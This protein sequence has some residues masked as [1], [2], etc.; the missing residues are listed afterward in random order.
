MLRIQTN[1][2]DLA[3]TFRQYALLNGRSIEEL[4]LKQSLQLV[5]G[6]KGYPGLLQLSKDCAPSK[7][8]IAADV[9]K[10]GW[11]IPREFADGRLG[12]GT[13]EQWTSNA[14]QTASKNNGR[15][16]RSKNFQAKLDALKNARPSLAVMQAFVIKWRVAHRFFV[17]AGWLKPASELGG[18]P[19]AESFPKPGGRVEV[20]ADGVTIINDHPGII[21]ANR[22]YQI[23]ARAIYFRILDMREYIVT[24]LAPAALKRAA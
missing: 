2:P 15:G 18:T 9:K 1:A 7:S 5:I 17:A 22:K 8:E 20:G 16:R 4:K 23:A 24:H 13:P 11:K 12:R 21:E 14:V 3:R 19:D 10:Q 6:S